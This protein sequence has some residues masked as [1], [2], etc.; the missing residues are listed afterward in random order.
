[1][2]SRI[3]VSIWNKRTRELKHYQNRH[4]HDCPL[5]HLSPGSVWVSE[6]VGPEEG[7]GLSQQSS[8]GAVVRLITVPLPK[9]PARLYSEGLATPPGSVSGSLAGS[10]WPI[11]GSATQVFSWQHVSPFCSPAAD[12]RLLYRAGCTRCHRPPREQECFPAHGT[13]SQQWKHSA[14]Q[15]CAVHRI[16]IPQVNYR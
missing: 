13:A 16:W 11:V 15:H 10:L 4:I 2:S 12:P 1:M 7:P 3:Q 6:V 14:V 8:P 5:L 9:A